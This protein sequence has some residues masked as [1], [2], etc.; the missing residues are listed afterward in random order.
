MF[1]ERT[2]Q[3]FTERWKKEVEERRKGRKEGRR[4]EEN[5][6]KYMAQEK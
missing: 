2:Y 5:K 6:R 3:I 1:R 4:K